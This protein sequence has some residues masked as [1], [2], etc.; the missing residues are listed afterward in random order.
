M[1]ELGFPELTTEQIELLCQTAEEAA[2][3]AVYSKVSQKEIDSLD[4]SVEAEGTKPVSVTVEIDLILSSKTKNVDSEA[5]V[6]EAAGVGQNA[7]ENFL[8]NLK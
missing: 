3:K 5:I 4:I 8:R 2:R 6:K 7:A 1:G